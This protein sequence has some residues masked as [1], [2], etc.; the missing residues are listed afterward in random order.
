[1]FYLPD[2]TMG[3]P[4]DFDWLKAFI[5]AGLYEDVRTGDITSLATISADKRSKAVLKI[6]DHGVLAGVEVA[7]QIFVHEDPA[8]VVTV[9]KKD[10]DEVSP[11]D[12]AFE[13]EAN[14]QALLRTER[15]V[16]NTMQRLSGT[17]TLS[18]RFKFEVEDLPVTILDTRKTTP[19]LRPLEKWAVTLGGC[20]N[21]RVGLYD[22]FMIKDNHVDAAGGIEQ[23]LNLV[24]AYQKTHGL[25]HTGITVEVR[26]FYELDTVLRVGG[27]TRVMFDNFSVQDLPIAVDIVGGRYETEASGGVELSTVRDIALTGVQFISVGA[28]THSAG[29]LDL[30]LKIQK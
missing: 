14:T 26:D 7:T 27:F 17:A 16:L 15:L 8:A 22:W 18:N 13:V 2:T 11:G 3:F 28:L 10:G 1:L 29:C 21:Y 12:I 20:A 24:H 5:V 25:Q 6:K 9:F 4:V 23:A 19:L 30:S